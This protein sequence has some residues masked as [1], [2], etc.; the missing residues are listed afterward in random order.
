MASGCFLADSSELAVRDTACSGSGSSPLA[1]AWVWGLT[2]H[3]NTVPSV[4]SVCSI[5]VRVSGAES[6]RDPRSTTS[7]GATPPAVTHGTPA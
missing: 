1:V 2:P 7:M 4:L 6:G 5:R 3:T